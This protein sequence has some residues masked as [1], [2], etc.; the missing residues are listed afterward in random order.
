MAA[1]RVCTFRIYYGDEKGSLLSDV[2]SEYSEDV[3]DLYFI[4]EDMELL[5]SEQY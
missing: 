2:G 5:N 1:K 4:E 3:V